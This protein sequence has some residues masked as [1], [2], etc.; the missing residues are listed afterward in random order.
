MFCVYSDRAE[1]SY[2]VKINCTFI[3]TETETRNSSTFSNI[4]LLICKIKLPDI[5]I[6][7]LLPKT[8]KDVNPCEFDYEIATH[9]CSK[10]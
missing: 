7:N 5:E 10:F 1:V 8:Y 2:T 6:T 9:T 3:F 4:E